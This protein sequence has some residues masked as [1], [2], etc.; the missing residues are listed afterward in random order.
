MSLDF[1]P[2]TEFLSGTYSYL[3]TDIANSLEIPYSLLRSTIRSQYGLHQSGEYSSSSSAVMSVTIVMSKD[4]A[5]H[6]T[7]NFIINN[8]KKTQHTIKREIT[9]DRL[10]MLKTPYYLL[11]FLMR[12]ALR[13]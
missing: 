10:V 13:I 5:S 12:M 8:N 3:K 1:H 11:S 6:T 4:S 9:L 7:P 2:P